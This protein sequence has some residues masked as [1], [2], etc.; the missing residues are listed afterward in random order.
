MPFERQW[1]F[2]PTTCKGCNGGASRVPEARH[3]RALADQTQCVRSAAVLLLRPCPE[4]HPS[5]CTCNAGCRMHCM[6]QQE[7]AWRLS[8]LDLPW[9]ALNCIMP[10]LR[11]IDKLAMF[12]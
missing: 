2:F 11:P 8:L 4:T 9:P 10:Q 6:A 5:L 1:M 12:R 7:V 3:G